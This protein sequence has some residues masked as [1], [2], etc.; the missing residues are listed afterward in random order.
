MEPLPHADALYVEAAQGWLDLNNSLEAADELAKIAPESRLHPAVLE[1]QWKVLAAGARWEASLSV[2]EAITHV[3]PDRASGWVMKSL[4]LRGLDRIQEAFD[5]LFP[6]V[7]D[8]PHV[9]AIAYDLACYACRLGRVDEAWGWLAKA[10]QADGT[11]RFEEM[12]LSDL[13]LKP[14]WP[15]LRYGQSGIRD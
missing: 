1:V 10:C 15:R 9:A 2:A 7:N 4:A 12:A 14:L 11:G 13:D 6:I 5:A 8:F 3:A